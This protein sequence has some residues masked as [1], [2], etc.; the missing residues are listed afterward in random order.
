MAFVA[1]N[2]WITPHLHCTSLRC[3]MALTPELIVATI[4]NACV[5][6]SRAAAHFRS[7]P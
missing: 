3:F 6:T 5:Y 1:I 4:V 7:V 2:A